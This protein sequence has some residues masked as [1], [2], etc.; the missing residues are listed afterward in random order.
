ME[1]Q[2]EQIVQLVMHEDIP[3]LDTILVHIFQSLGIASCIG[4]V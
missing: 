3:V 2:N 1:L 4:L